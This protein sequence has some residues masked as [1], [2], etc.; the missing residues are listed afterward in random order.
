M[1]GK[2]CD[3]KLNLNVNLYGFK[4]MAIELRYKLA[5]TFNEDQNQSAH[6]IR[7]LDFRLK[8]MLNSWLPIKRQANLGLQ[9]TVIVLSQASI[10]LLRLQG[11]SSLL[12]VTWNA[13]AFAIESNA[14]S[15][16]VRFRGDHSL[17]RQASIA[18]IEPA[19]P[20]NKTSSECHIL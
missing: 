4:N 6:F 14:Q 3:C 8:M 7:V 12:N 16:M 19:T 15:A 5:C 18:G 11:N 13:V 20:I 2:S 10:H 1:K 17:I 9:W